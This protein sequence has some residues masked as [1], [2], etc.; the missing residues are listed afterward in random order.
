MTTDDAL[1]DTGASVYVCIN[2]SFAERVIKRLNPKIVNKFEP[3]GVQGY[4]GKD[5]Q[6]IRQ[7]LMVHFAV[8][9]RT[10]KDVPV[11]VLNMKHDVIFGKLWFEKHDVLPD[12]CRRRLVFPPK[13]P[14]DS[15]ERNLAMDDADTWIKHPKF[16]KDAERRDNRIAKEDY[17]REAQRKAAK[18]AIPV[19]VLSRK[20]D[21]HPQPFDRKYE[22]PSVEE[23]Q[24]EEEDHL[25]A[26]AE[27][28]ESGEIT[29]K[30]L[31]EPPAD[32][33]NLPSLTK[34]MFQSE[35]YAKMDRA[36]RGEPFIAAPREETDEP[37]ESMADDWHSDHRGQYRMRRDGTGWYKEYATYI[38]SMD[39][40]SFQRMVRVDKSQERV[41]S[42]SIDQLSAIIDRKKEEEFP[43]EESEELKKRALEVI[44]PEYHD[45]LRT[46]SKVDSDTL[47]PHRTGVDHR[48]EFVEGKTAEDLGYSPLYK[49]SLD[50]LEAVREYLQ[51]QLRRGFI[52]PS[53]AP[54]ASPVLFVGKSD[55]SLRFCVDYR[56]LNNLTV[57]DRYPLPLIEET[58]SRISKARYFTKIDVRQAFHR[59]RIRKGDE[60][61]TTFRTRYGSYRYKVLP[62]GMS[63][64]PAT[65]QR[66]INDTLFEYLDDFCSAYV[67]DVL[68]YSNTL[69]EHRE[70]VRKV[71]SKLRDAGLQVNI[72]KSE[73]HV[74]E[75]KFLGYII[76]AEGIRVDPEKVRVVRDWNAP[77][78]VKGVQSFL[79]FCNFYRKFMRN[80]SR[81]TK[82]ISNLTKQ[83]VPYVWSEQCEE[84]FLRLKE[85]LTSSPLLKHFD[86][87]LPT[88]VETDASDGVCAGVLSQLHDDGVWHPVA[89]Y[90]KTMMPA[91]LNYGIPDKEL[92]AVVL[93]LKTWRP[94]L[95]G[96]QRKEP[97]LVITDHLA[98]ETFSLKQQLNLRQAGWASL[99]SEYNFVITF[100]PGK[101]NVLADALSRKQD[102]L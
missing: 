12:C 6:Q 78:S 37:D 94:E 30:A 77:T 46:F 29:D 70:H 75:T 35:A 80:Y 97:F 85:V 21:S 32:T 14:R 64:G 20:E 4:D 69:E 48:I 87:D 36:L 76:G 15:W 8:G 47:P 2:E 39:A 99:F 52:E 53:D 57:K 43:D 33:H 51:D 41:E 55:G 45:L 60:N 74:A 56:K 82:P 28:P 26:E 67:D 10:V 44:P 65:F 72:K 54:W 93:A 25:P 91:E 88:K 3:R 83:G 42:I 27:D 49:M 92:L 63:N 17:R 9:G 16:Q 102:E 40:S 7:A 101:E 84:A 81:I 98:L 71:L 31:K 58:L 24:E 1:G 61:F 59:I 100:R 66:Y 22:A 50:E 79:G 73:F 68:I 19:K 11:F 89:F 86:Y 23:V 95:V 38:M 90:S 13:M 5:G 62:F 34:G 96:Q 18:Q